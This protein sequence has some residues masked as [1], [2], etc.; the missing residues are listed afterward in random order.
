M[1]NRKYKLVVLLFLAI[2][3]Q[4]CMI[5]VILPV[6]RMNSSTFI[7]ERKYEIAVAGE[8][9]QAYKVTEKGDYEASPDIIA[10]L[11]F[12]IKLKKEIKLIGDFSISANEGKSHH[13]YLFMA[14]I[15]KVF[16][17]KEELHYAATFHGQYSFNDEEGG[18]EAYEGSIDISSQMYA[19]GMTNEVVYQP[20][21]N[22]VLRAG[23][24]FDHVENRTTINGGYDSDVEF[25]D[26]VFGI[27][28]K[29]SFRFGRFELFGGTSFLFNTASS[30]FQKDTSVL[31][32]GS[33]FSFGE[34]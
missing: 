18:S 5:T 8:L 20:K 12:G 19:F 25:Y 30:K 9:T 3:F 7:D 1:L 2:F 28:V 33:K 14:G 4:S 34:L 26:N 32:L 23:L 13:G 11:E 10:D 15:E 16:K 31:Y 22:F 21:K 24:Y 17:L 6:K 29:A 27:P